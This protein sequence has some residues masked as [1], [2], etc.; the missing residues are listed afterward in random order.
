MLEMGKNVGFLIPRWMDLLMVMVENPKVPV[1]RLVVD[2]HY[3]V[4]HVLRL[5]GE[6]ERLGFFVC[7][8]DVHD[9]RCKKYVVTKLGKDVY[10]SVKFVVGVVES[11]AFRRET[12]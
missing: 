7:S 6:F 12:K 8:L 1:T 2:K 3:G 4:G 5:V 9:K 10:E 11:R